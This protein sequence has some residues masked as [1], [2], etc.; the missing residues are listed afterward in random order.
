MIIPKF[1]FFRYDTHYV[2]S[3]NKRPTIVHKM[4]NAPFLL[5]TSSNHKY[6]SNH[7][8]L[9]ISETEGKQKRESRTVK[10]MELCHQRNEINIF[11]AIGL[12]IFERFSFWKGAKYTQHLAEF[13]THDRYSV[14]TDSMTEKMN[15]LIH[16]S[17]VN[18]FQSQNNILESQNLEHTIGR[19]NF[20]LMYE[21][22][23]KL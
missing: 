23:C 3:Y 19:Q 8:P 18:Y 15:Q 16:K 11:R 2:T 6:I 7:L 14:N 22:A 21:K 1:E 13:L 4:R 20:S 12:Q 17:L 5:N 9:F 10:D